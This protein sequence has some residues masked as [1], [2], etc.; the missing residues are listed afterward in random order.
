MCC[1][2]GRGPAQPQEAALEALSHCLKDGRVND[3]LTV[4][5]AVATVGFPLSR[6]LQPVIANLVGSRFCVIWN[7]EIA[8]G[9]EQ[10]NYVLKASD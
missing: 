4:S 2:I 6:G 9:G 3:V 8:D 7:E 1:G 10:R 5:D